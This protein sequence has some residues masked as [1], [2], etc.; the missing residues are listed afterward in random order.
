MSRDKC[1]GRASSRIAPSAAMEGI[2]YIS[3]TVHTVLA[4]M[5]LWML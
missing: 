3:F 2:R 1:D 5:P 4:E